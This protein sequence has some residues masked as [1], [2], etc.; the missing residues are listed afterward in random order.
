MLPP[1]ALTLTDCRLLR[2]RG[3]VETVGVAPG[4]HSSPRRVSTLYVYISIYI[5]IYNISLLPSFF[6]SL[7]RAMVLR[8]LLA[9][10]E[11][12]RRSSS[13][14]RHGRRTRNFPPYK[15]T[16]TMTTMTATT[17]ADRPFPSLFSLSSVARATATRLA[18]VRTRPC[19]AFGY[20]RAVRQSAAIAAAAANQSVPCICLPHRP[21]RHAPSSFLSLATVR[22]C[23]R[24]H[25]PYLQR[26]GP[27]AARSRNLITSSTLLCGR[28]PPGND[29]LLDR[30]P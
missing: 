9:M 1:A 13:H 6:P 3:C 21:P 12:R 28:R 20:M 29:D 5:C 27:T 4:P 18:G 8:L 17:R 24:A 15:E 26:L 2:I 25:P 11:D 7:S 30:F 19:C 23:P 10:A 14:P 16:A 22:R